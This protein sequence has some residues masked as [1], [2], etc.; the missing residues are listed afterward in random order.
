MENKKIIDKIRKLMA[1]AGNNPEEHEAIAAAL[2]AQKLMAEHGIQLADVEDDSSESPEIIEA[3]YDFTS[4]GHS[5][6]KWKWKLA[7]IVAENF[8]CKIYVIDRK[9]IVFYGLE[10]DAK[11]AQEVFVNLYKIGNRL[12]NRLYYRYKKEGRSTK[13]IMNDYLIG[14]TD[15]VGNALGK[16]CRA[17][18]IVTPKEVEEGWE[19]RSAHM[20]TMRN[21]LSC[22]GDAEARA[23][24]KADGES[25][26]SQKQLKA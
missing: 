5:M 7:S 14:F 24:G 25:Y 6:S 13:G 2:K 16:Q 21:R 1:L 8:R 17:L 22:G 11:I 15:G 12:A 20:G 9:A 3:R 23:K 4:G 26:A 19:L 10:S 18:M